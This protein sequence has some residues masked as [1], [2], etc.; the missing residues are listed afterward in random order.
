M[1]LIIVSALLP[2]VPLISA[3]V[4]VVTDVIALAVDMLMVVTVKE[5][6]AVA[7]GPI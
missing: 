4:A 6:N 3:V 1:T 7:S 5:S 2:V